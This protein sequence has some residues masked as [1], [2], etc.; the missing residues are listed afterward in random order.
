MHRF[1]I[2]A[3]LDPQSLLR[4]VGA[5]AQRSIVPTRM[6]M[7]VRGGAMRIDVIVEGLAPAQAATITARLR[8]VV[9]VIDA[10]MEEA[11]A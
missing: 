5:F 4:V 11:V 8:E 2:A 9:A 6:D 10:E 1:R 7:Q 3:I